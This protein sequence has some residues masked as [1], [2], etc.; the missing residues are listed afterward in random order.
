MARQMMPGRTGAIWTWAARAATLALCALLGACAADTNLAPAPPPPLVIEQEPR[1]ATPSRPA[2]A[3]TAQPTPRPQPA[4]PPPRDA[5]PQSEARPRVGEPEKYTPDPSMLVGLAPDQIQKLV[6]PPG[7]T[8]ESP[9]ATVWQ[10]FSSGCVFEIYLY[11]EVRGDTLRALGYGIL[12]SI[13]TA[14]AK[15]ECFSQIWQGGV[16]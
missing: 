11:R 16:G 2:P 13:Q 4:A 3:T 8:R 14:D 9:P 5:A 7:A 12:G 6:G 1:P 10:Y 15:R